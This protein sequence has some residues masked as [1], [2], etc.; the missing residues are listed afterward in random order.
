MPDDS[1]ANLWIR[2][3]QNNP[4]IA[5]FV[6]LAAALAGI[7]WLSNSLTTIGG[8]FKE[9][10]SAPSVAVHEPP[11]IAAAIPPAKRISFSEEF[12]LGERDTYA[13]P[14]GVSVRTQFIMIN[15]QGTVAEIGA[16]A[17]GPV[18]WLDTMTRGQQI[19][20]TRSDCDR[21]L[22]TIRDVQFH[23]NEGMTF[24]QLRKMGPMAELLVTRKVIGTIKG[25]C[26]E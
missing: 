2:K 13:S 5:A 26:E 3:L 25:H 1:L 7:A 8:I 16:S 12:T 6:V 23:P 9:K 11:A 15:D 24:E 21:L 19:N 20:L 18:E 22:V 17:V 4:I 10:Q 14:H